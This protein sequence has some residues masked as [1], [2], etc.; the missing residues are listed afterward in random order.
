MSLIISVSGIR[1][2]IGGKESENLT[3][4]DIV[5]FT[6]AYAIWIK[7]QFTSPKV[8]IGRDGRISGKMVS[9]ECKKSIEV[10]G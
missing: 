8:I 1:G 4:L 7:K 2:T 3:P 6:T 10:S 9:D 5:K